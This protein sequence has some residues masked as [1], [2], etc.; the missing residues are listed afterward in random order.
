VRAL[1]TL[2]ALGPKPG[3]PAAILAKKQHE[4]SHTQEGA[5]QGGRRYP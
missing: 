5:T 3:P 2:N 4:T 1:L